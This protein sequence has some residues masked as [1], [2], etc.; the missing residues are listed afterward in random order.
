MYSDDTVEGPRAP[1][2]KLTARHSSLTR[3]LKGCSPVSVVGLVRQPSYQLQVIR[4]SYTPW[5]KGALSGPVQWREAFPMAKPGD[6]G[7]AR[8]RHL[9]R[10]FVR[11]DRGG[12]G[13]AHPA[14][15]AA[16]SGAARQ[17]QGLVWWRHLVD[18]G[19]FFVCRARS[20][21]ARALPDRIARGHVT[22]QHRAQPRRHGAHTISGHTH[23][24]TRAPASKRRATPVRASPP[25]RGSGPPRCAP[26][27]PRIPLPSG[28]QGSGSRLRS[29]WDRRAPPGPRIPLPSGGQGSGSR[30]RYLWDCR[31]PPGPRI[32]LPSGGQGSGSRLR[33]QS[34]DQP[35]C[36]RRAPSPKTATREVSSSKRTFGGAAIAT[37]ASTSSTPS[38]RSAT[39]RRI[40]FQDHGKRRDRGDS[41]PW[42]MCWI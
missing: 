16:R 32:P 21:F 39:R 34:P 10:G 11:R 1:A 19:N 30:L 14:A 17:A 13:A 40:Y 5:R 7:F 4:N 35:D 41:G 31:A 18:L 27:G 26:P 12:R 36:D 15:G 23:R 25:A 29:L 2:V 3:V 20:L 6:V 33:S 38:S 22:G 9:R 24:A 8:F 42:V 28:G 37:A